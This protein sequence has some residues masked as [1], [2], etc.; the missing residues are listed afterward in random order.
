MSLCPVKKTLM[1]KWEPNKSYTEDAVDWVWTVLR[2]NAGPIS[3]EYLL[4]RF[5][6]RKDLYRRYD[7]EDR[8]HRIIAQ[9]DMHKA[10]DGMIRK[11]KSTGVHTGDTET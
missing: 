11:I 5:T 8:L 3:F 10:Q 2:A 9:W 4:M 6:G 1:P 7:P